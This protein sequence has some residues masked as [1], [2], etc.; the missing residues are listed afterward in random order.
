[1]AKKPIKIK[2]PTP[3]SED[4][5][6]VRQDFNTLIDAKK[7]CADKERHKKVMAYAL[8]MKQQAG[9]VVTDMLEEKA[10]SEYE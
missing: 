4:D 1:M 5:W 8:K 6:Q 7:I 2:L 3:V 9:E 10:E